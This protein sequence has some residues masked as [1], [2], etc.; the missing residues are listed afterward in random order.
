MFVDVRFNIVLTRQVIQANNH[1]IRT[2]QYKQ[3]IQKEHEALH[4]NNN[5]T[6]STSS[7][8]EDESEDVEKMLRD[9]YN[10]KRGAS[11]TSTHTLDIMS[12]LRKFLQYPRMDSKEDI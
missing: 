11:H 12:I 3:K 9:L 1:L 4:N 8:C 6:P 2:W 7:A 5:C 10:K